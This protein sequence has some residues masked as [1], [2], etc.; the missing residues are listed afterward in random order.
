MPSETRFF[1]WSNLS[2]F[3]S[4][5]VADGEDFGR[6]LHAAPR[7]IGDVQQAVDAAQVH[8]RAVVGDVLDDALDDRAFLQRREQ[9][10][11]LC[12]LARFEHGAARHH[13]V[14]ALAV[15]LDDLEVHLL[16]LVRRGVLHRPD[17]DQR[18]GQEGAYAVHHH[19]E[20]ALDLAVDDALTTVPFSSASSRS[21]HAARRF[22]LSRESR[23][24]P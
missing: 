24:S 12:A 2:T 9:R 10:L 1:S 13:D 21:S 3:A 17:V 14:V 19:G 4:H 15:E 20:A 6:M 8:E 23:V 16:V 5:F 18:A 7:E 11:A 22:A